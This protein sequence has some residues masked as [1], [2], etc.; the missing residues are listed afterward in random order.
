MRVEIGKVYKR[1]FTHNH[2]V[3]DKGLPAKTT[4][5]VLIT[6]IQST[7][8]SR[9]VFWKDIKKLNVQHDPVED[10]FFEYDS[11]NIKFEENYIAT[12]LYG[13]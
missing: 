1:I 4:R 13:R 10:N 9:K 2:C 12:I 3:N 5:L 6:S 8:I 11:I 7:E